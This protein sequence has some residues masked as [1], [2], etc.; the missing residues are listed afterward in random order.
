MVHFRMKYAFDIGAPLDE[1]SHGVFSADVVSDKRISTVLDLTVPEAA[2]GLDLLESDVPEKQLLAARKVEVSDLAEA[3]FPDKFSYLDMEDYLASSCFN[4]Q[5]VWSSWRRSVISKEILTSTILS[6]FVHLCLVLI[7][8]A[9]PSY[10]TSGNGNN[11]QGA[12]MVRLVE[13]DR[14]VVPTDERA[15]SRDA[16]A[17]LPM[18]AKRALRRLDRVPT[19][20]SAPQRPMLE[21]SA[22][23]TKDVPSLKDVSSEQEKKEAVK[24]ETFK[25]PVTPLPKVENPITKERQPDAT[26]M[27]VAKVDSPHAYDSSSSMPSKASLPRITGAAAGKAGDDYRNK[28]LSAIS[29]AAFY[30]KKALVEKIHGETIVTFTVNKNGSIIHLSIKRP[31]GYNVLDDAAISIVKNASRHF[32]SIPSELTTD[33]LSYDVPIIFKK[34]S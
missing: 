22:S 33:S 8:T 21:E 25:D 14:D 13:K 26:L 11:G 7:L 1:D 28:I 16:L 32:P 29:A 10:V 9:M 34:R 5:S 20:H 17:S 3:Y 6:G 24:N 18:L 23:G 31:S 2:A 4:H 19:P 30:P 12:V 27:D 15:G